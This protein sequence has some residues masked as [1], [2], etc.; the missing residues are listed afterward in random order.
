MKNIEHLSQTANDFH[1]SEE[2]ELKGCLTERK[3]EIRFPSCVPTV[4]LWVGPVEGS[5]W[6]DGDIT[7]PWVQ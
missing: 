5:V 1:Q 4:Q 2:E 7:K 3:D 6:S